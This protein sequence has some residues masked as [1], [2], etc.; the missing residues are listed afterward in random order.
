MNVL[1]C[2]QYPRWNCICKEIYVF[3]DGQKVTRI[4]VNIC[5]Q[6]HFLLPD[7]YNLGCSIRTMHPTVFIPFSPRT[8]C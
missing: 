8:G 2:Y 1:C 4:S 7:N 3:N 5:L 6:F